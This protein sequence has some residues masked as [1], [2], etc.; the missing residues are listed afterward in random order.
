M[1]DKLSPVLQRPLLV[2]IGLFLATIFVSSL[3][4][5]MEHGSLKVHINQP[6]RPAA[7]N[8][9]APPAGMEGAQEQ[10]HGAMSGVGGMM[11]ALKEN[12]D[13][14]NL[15]L[16]LSQR[17]LANQNWETAEVFLKRAMVINPGEPRI[18]NLLGMT[19]FQREQY[20]DAADYYSRAAAM[21]ATDYLSRFNLGMIYANFLGRPDKGK[22]YFQEVLEVAPQDEEVRVRAR[23]ELESIE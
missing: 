14:L 4:Y 19:A 11:E 16:G 7:M 10:E 15:L 20:E 6:Q 13:D 23:E 18:L 3:M 5:R 8:E 17:F 1:A 12:P 22:M 21:N 9:G 2:A